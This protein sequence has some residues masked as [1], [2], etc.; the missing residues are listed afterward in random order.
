MCDYH[1]A[2]NQ[3]VHLNNVPITERCSTERGT[4]VRCEP[5]AGH[6]RAFNTHII[7]AWS[8]VIWGLPAPSGALIRIVG[9]AVSAGPYMLPSSS[10]SYSVRSYPGLCGFQ[11][12]LGREA[13][14]RQVYS[15]LHGIAVVAG[16]LLVARF[17]SCCLRIVGSFRSLLPNRPVPAIA[18]N[19]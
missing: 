10:T 18:S 12:A 7:G 4:A 2:C 15:S 8:V 13:V 16:P 5:S 17:S 6:A 11:G 1:V 3:S 19:D 14:V 9:T